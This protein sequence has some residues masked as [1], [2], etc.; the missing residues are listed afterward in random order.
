MADQRRG[1]RLQSQGLGDV[2]DGRGT[3][4]LRQDIGTAPALQ[5]SFI[6]FAA[7]IIYAY[8]YKFPQVY[9]F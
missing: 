2:E 8:T 5:H 4:E 7:L 3:A 1:H 6:L 9:I